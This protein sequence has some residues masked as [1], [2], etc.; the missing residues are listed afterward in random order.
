MMCSIRLSLYFIP[1]ALG[2]LQIAHR[3]R[4]S[5]ALFIDLLFELTDFVIAELLESEEVLACFVVFHAKR[6]VFAFL[7]LEFIVRCCESL[8]EGRTVHLERFVCALP[9]GELLLSCVGL[10]LQCGIVLK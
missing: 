8:T 3:P 2:T 7:L 6:L 4:G 5:S 10:S 9:V 1:R